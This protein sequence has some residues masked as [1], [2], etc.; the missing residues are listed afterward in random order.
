MLARALLPLLAVAHVP[1][2]SVLVIARTAAETAE[3]ELHLSRQRFRDFEL[4]VEWGD[5]IPRAWNR[6]LA[7]ARG[8][9]I[10]FTETDARPL[11]EWWLTQLVEQMNGDDQRM[12]K[13]LE[14]VGTP[15]NLSN[16][17]VSRAT[18]QGMAFDEGFRWAEDTDL[19]SRLLAAGCSLERRE[20]APVFHSFDPVSRK[21]LRRAFGYGM[22]WARIRHRYPQPVERAEFSRLLLQLA[23]TTVQILG[24]ACGWLRYL[25]ERRARA[26]RQR[27]LGKARRS[28]ARTVR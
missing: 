24:M 23:I 10:V 3:I 19:F 27:S 26:S 28:L 16:V 13:G 4:I 9:Y 11:S 5:T 25:P 2:V 1:L 17:I 6:A 22:Y 21:A 18:L 14:V 15:W 7:R 12:V 20:V 8:T